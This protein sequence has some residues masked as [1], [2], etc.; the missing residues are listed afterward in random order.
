MSELDRKIAFNKG[1][2]GGMWASGCWPNEKVH[3]ILL[4]GP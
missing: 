1:R 3:L 2:S 4:A